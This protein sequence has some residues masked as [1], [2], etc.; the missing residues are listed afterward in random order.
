MQTDWFQTLDEYWG[1]GDTTYSCGFNLCSD[2]LFQCYN[3]LTLC[4]S[5]E[6]AYLTWNS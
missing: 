2:Q 3:E 4:E 6:S 1:E 5:I